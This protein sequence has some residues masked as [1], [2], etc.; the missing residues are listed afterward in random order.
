MGGVFTMIILCIFILS[1]IAGTAI[2]FTLWYVLRNP[3]FN[4]LKDDEDTDDA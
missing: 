3:E 4:P 2:V 1:C